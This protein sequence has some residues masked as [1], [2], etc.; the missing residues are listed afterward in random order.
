MKYL[1]RPLNRIVVIDSKTDS[2]VKYADNGI[3]ID[4]FV[5]D[6]NDRTLTDLMPLLDCKECYCN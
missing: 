4:E 5:G 3:F 6:V 1:N 2:L